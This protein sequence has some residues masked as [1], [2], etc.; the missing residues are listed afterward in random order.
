MASTE[1]ALAV[2]LQQ[3][4]TRADHRYQHGRTMLDSQ[5]AMVRF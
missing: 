1:Q 3:V 2:A 4:E 5:A